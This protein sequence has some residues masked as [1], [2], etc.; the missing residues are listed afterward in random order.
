M[1]EGG[2]GQHEL[3][4]FGSAS[5]AV[6]DLDSESLRTDIKVNRDKNRLVGPHS[7]ILSDT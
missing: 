3:V 6:C 5:G 4:E 2:D 7:I 1:V